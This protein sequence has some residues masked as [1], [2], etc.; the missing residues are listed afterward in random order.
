MDEPVD[1]FSA[2]H[3]A[4]V[5]LPP[6]EA[7]SPPP[8]I[9]TS[10]AFFEREVE[11]VFRHSWNCVGRTDYIEKPGDFFTR[12]LAGVPI[13]VLRDKDGTIRAF[14][15][16]CRH[17]GAQLLEGEGNCRAIKCPYHGWVY[18]LDGALNGAPGMEAARDFERGRNGLRPIRLDCR[19]GFIFVNFDDEAAGLDI[20]LG[21]WGPLF[22]CYGLEDMVTV[23]RRE[24][25]IA[26]NW[27]LATEVFIEEY[28]APTVHQNTLYRR[29]LSMHGYDAVPGSFST[30]FG[31][32][33][34]S[35]AL[36]EGQG[37]DPFPPIP[38]LE[39]Q[40]KA[41][42]RWTVTYSGFCFAV[43]IDAMWFIECYPLGPD[44]TRYAWVNCFPR[45]TA[46]RADY[47]RVAPGYYE[48]WDI[49]VIEDNAILERQQRGLASPFARPGRLQ[50]RKEPIV[51][52]FGRWLADRVIG[53]APAAG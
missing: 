50:P 8:W 6:E 33:E 12:E 7:E 25:E 19:G 11:R 4:R 32:H 48:R 1:I 40:A 47:A 23:R 29:P 52:H 43:T 28:H 21:G 41:G 16:T 42:T 14:A 34:G 37:H 27:K 17:R 35:R 51:A 3:Y 38:T 2:R 49:A 15:N 22:D 30:V 20:W 5:R 39:G 31:A 10:R 24:G 45:S 46:S 53:N 13:A 18:G 44:R 9:Y 36:I 26:A